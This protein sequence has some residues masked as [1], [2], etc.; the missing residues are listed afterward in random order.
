MRFADTDGNRRTAADP[1]W[2]PLSATPADPSYPGA[3]S[4]LSAAASEVLTA[5]YGD[6]SFALTSPAL[7]GVTRT[8]RSFHDAAVEAG[9]SRIYAGVHT[10]VDHRAGFVLGSQVGS[11]VLR[12]R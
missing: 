12:S 3:H 9:L 6:V 8:F 10:R 4:A 11:Y 5:L 7:P 1:A 2:T